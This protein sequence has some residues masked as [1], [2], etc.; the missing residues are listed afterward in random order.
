MEETKKVEETKLNL[1][2]KLAK[3]RKTVEV[4]Q[5]DKT[6]GMGKFS[7]K[8][9]SDEDILAKLTIGLE[10]YNLT[11]F[12]RFVPST[13]KVE[14]Y[15]YSKTDTTKDGTIFEKNVDEIFV[16]AETEWEWVNNDSPDE[17]L[18]VPWVMVGHQTDASKA[19]GSGI[20]YS[21]RYF[22]MGF[23]DI[24]TPEN[25]VDEWRAKQEQAEEDAK[26][27]VLK[28]IIERIDSLK[29]EYVVKNPDGSKVLEKTLK[30]NIVIDGNVSANYLKIKDPVMAAKV[31]KIM[32]TLVNGNETTNKEDK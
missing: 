6:A 15:H 19:L 2:Q 32:D 16:Y 28:P 29:K 9:V 8:Y 20:S 26:A 11:L 4:I 12:P 23:F 24:S 14:P 31:L 1:Y 7:Y 25:N 18:V 30:D 27:T 5:K 22:L 13:L 3:I 21:R 17:R 10:K